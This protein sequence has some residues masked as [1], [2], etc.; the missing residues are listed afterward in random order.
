MELC[1]KSKLAL[2]AGPSSARLDRHPAFADMERT[3]DWDSLDALP[4][5]DSILTRVGGVYNSAEAE[6]ALRPNQRD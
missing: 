4:Y 1:L 5:D 2:S 6:E 3:S